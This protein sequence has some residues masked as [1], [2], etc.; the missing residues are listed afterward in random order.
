M[1]CIEVSDSKGLDCPLGFI[2]LGRHL[3][4]F[5]LDSSYWTPEQYREQWVGACR[6]LVT[7][8]RDSAVML[9]VSIQDP[10]S[11]AGVGAWVLYRAGERVFVQEH[12]LFYKDMPQP[13]AESGP[14][15]F[16]RERRVESAGRRISEWEV[17]LADVAHYVKAAG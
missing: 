6:E 17:A 2:L 12:L 4:T 8:A 7:R 14:W 10:A 5:P 16:W 9:V 13:F 11:T 1:F 15:T 3:E